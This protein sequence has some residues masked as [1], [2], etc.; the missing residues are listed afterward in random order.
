MYSNYRATDS[1]RQQSLIKP[2]KKGIARTA[3][4][5]NSEAIDSISMLIAVY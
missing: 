2:A 1:N 4:H 3:R 5:S